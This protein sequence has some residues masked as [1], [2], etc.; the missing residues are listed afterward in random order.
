VPQISQTLEKANDACRT[1]ETSLSK[2]KKI[3]DANNLI[4]YR[5]IQMTEQT[6]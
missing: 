1:R 5:S 6:L 4:I 3:K 2:E